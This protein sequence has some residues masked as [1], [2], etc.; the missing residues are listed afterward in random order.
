MTTQNQ[1]ISNQENAKLGG[2]KTNEGKL[3]VRF[4]ALKH[5]VWGEL[6][7]E[8]ESEMYQGLLSDLMAE[9]QPNGMI[10]QVL[11]ERIAVAYLRLKRLAK[12]EHEFVK[13]TIHPLEQEIGPI[14]KNADGYKPSIDKQAVESMFSIYSRYETSIEN[15]MYRAIRELREVKTG[16]VLQNGGVN[17]SQ[18]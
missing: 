3:M 12:A 7:T 15:K 10:E 17:D 5:G 1:I 16:F 6:I 2:V 18:S 4:N 8:Y 13:A 11:V 9:L 14:F